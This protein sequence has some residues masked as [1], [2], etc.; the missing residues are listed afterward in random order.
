MGLVLQIDIMLHDAGQ[1]QRARWDHIDLKVDRS[2]F[3]LNVFAMVNLSRLLVPQ[4]R[5][6]EGGGKFAIMSSL[7]GKTALPFSA[8][9]CATKHALH[10]GNCLIYNFN[11]TVEVISLGIL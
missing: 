10:V 9:Y 3:D 7:A 11:I 2:M 8:T 1:S 5:R 4:F 6:Q